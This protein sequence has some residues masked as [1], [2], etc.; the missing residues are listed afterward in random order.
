MNDQPDTKTLI[1][2]INKFILRP[3]SYNK[4]D[5]AAQN[6][7]E[8]AYKFY[9]VD[10]QY[11]IEANNI[12][13]TSPDSESYGPED[14]IVD[15]ERN[16]KYRCVKLPFNR[17]IYSVV[18]VSAKISHYL[19]IL[20]YILS[21]KIRRYLNDITLIYL[22]YPL[23]YFVYERYKLY[24]VE[25]DRDIYNIFEYKLLFKGT[26]SNPVYPFLQSALLNLLKAAQKKL[27][28]EEREIS[29][30]QTYTSS[31]ICKLNVPVF[32]KRIREDYDIDLPPDQPRP[33][34]TYYAISHHTEIDQPVITVGLD[35]PSCGYNIRFSF[36]Y[37]VHRTP[38]EDMQYHKYLMDMLAFTTY[39]QSLFKVCARLAPQAMYLFYP[40]KNRCILYE[41]NV[42]IYSD[43]YYEHYITLGDLVTS[44][45][46]KLLRSCY[47]PLSPR[48]ILSYTRKIY[49]CISKEI[50]RKRN[51]YEYIRAPE[52]TAQY[53][54]LSGTYV[55]TEGN[56]VPNKNYNLLDHR[57]YPGAINIDYRFGGKVSTASARLLKILETLTN[58]NYHIMNN[59]VR[60]LAGYCRIG[61]C[62]KNGFVFVDCPSEIFDL[63]KAF[64]AR[65]KKNDNVYF[66]DTEELGLARTIPKLLHY[67]LN[68][69]GP[70]FV[71]EVKRTY[72]RNSIKRLRR[73][74]SGV[75]I[76][77]TPKN[78]TPEEG[79]ALDMWQSFNY[80]VYRY[81]NNIPI[82]I[83][84]SSSQ[85]INY[86]ERYFQNRC[87]KMNFRS[88]WITTEEYHTCL[89]YIRELTD[90]DISYIFGTI[91]PYGLWYYEAKK[92]SGYEKKPH[93]PKEP[94]LYSDKDILRAFFNECCVVKSGARINTE[95]LF[96]AYQLYNKSQ[97]NRDIEDVSSQ[98]F[99]KLMAELVREKNDKWS[100]SKR[101]ADKPLIKKLENVR[102]RC[103]ENLTLKRKY[104]PSTILL[105]ASTKRRRGL[106][107]DKVFGEEKP[108]GMSIVIKNIE[109]SEPEIGFVR[110]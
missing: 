55:I 92:K 27:V 70:I 13:E 53:N 72:A 28:D 33:R 98:T 22:T 96:Q 67:Q 65:I 38:P 2:N 46:Q 44:T 68:G 42:I 66:A 79:K 50:C 18:E 100:R 40:L 35:L 91:I 34:K 74:L 21:R 80:A 82:L 52:I 86:M 61:E 26:Y 49:N 15:P 4:L 5:Q 94:E 37:I 47:I 64:F 105:P 104:K 83:R 108:K 3:S 30:G 99:S 1:N 90:T 54:S 14:I 95:T 71:D 51:L 31:R 43:E 57:S 87:Y 93:V 25:M 24:C 102:P 101:A 10:L 32:E 12:S 9:R 106:T 58:N 41:D 23:Q 69:E 84:C 48:S 109:S 103:Y 110:L 73:L 63:Y 16:L 62:Q 20:H 39:R 77:D 85:D 6:Y 78:I 11:I 29:L 89:D 8:T 17:P 36:D 45:M 81:K 59:L 76:Y 60:M 107:A 19:N 7:I 75:A 56:P 97:L 88:Q